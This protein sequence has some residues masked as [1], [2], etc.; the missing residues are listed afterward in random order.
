MR[1]RNLPWPTDGPQVGD[2]V[3][4]TREFWG[5]VLTGTVTR[6]FVGFDWYDEEDDEWER[7]SPSVSVQVD[8]LPPGWPYP[9]D[10]FAPSLDDLEVLERDVGGLR[11]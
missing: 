9:E 5:A 1:V 10:K 6:L 7:S 11:E 3:R 4:T 8:E 2:R